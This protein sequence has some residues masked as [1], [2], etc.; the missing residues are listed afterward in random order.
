VAKLD[1]DAAAAFLDT[2][3]A[4]HWTSY[5]DLAVAGG[6]SPGAAQGIVSWIGSRGH[7]LHGVHRVLNTHGEVNPGWTPAGPGLPADAAA[8]RALL[9]AEGVRFLG[10]RADPAQRRR[11]R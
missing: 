11:P 4:G 7:E 1:L 10:G 3:A 5:G 8:V 2:V 9:E 6:R